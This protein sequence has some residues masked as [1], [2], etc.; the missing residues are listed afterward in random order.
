MIPFQPFPK[1]P[2]IGFF[3]PISA[4]PRDMMTDVEFL[5]GMLKKLNEVIKQVN[6]NTEFINNYSGKIEEIEAKINQL[7]SD[8]DEFKADTMADINARFQQIVIELNSAIATCLVQANAYTDG[9]FAQLEQEIEQIVVGQITVYDPTTGVRSPLQTVIDNL[10]DSGRADALTA[11]E[12][13][14][15][16]SG[17]P[18]TATA[19]DAYELT[20]IDYDSNAKNLLV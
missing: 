20:A 13:D 12:Y 11:T 4:D 16:D 8:M 5:L 7:Y 1:I 2:P 10:Y 9:K 17:D 14:T 18:L 6:Q 19:Y 15:L 3:Q